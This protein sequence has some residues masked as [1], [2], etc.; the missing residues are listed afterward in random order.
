M[1]LVGVPRSDGQPFEMRGVTLFEIRDGQVVA[2][3]L[4]MEDVER[5]AVSIEQ[6]VQTRSG[7]RPQLPP[8]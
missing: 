3:S 2:G 8:K 7:R 1:A 5:E 6:I 4:Y